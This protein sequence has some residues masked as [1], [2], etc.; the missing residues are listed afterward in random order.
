MGELPLAM[1]PFELELRAGDILCASAAA[2][3]PCLHHHTSASSGDIH[4][5]NGSHLFDMR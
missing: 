2:R 4:K 1:R 5:V 3:H